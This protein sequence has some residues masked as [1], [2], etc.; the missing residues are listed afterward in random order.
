M[1]LIFQIKEEKYK[2]II[3]TPEGEIDFESGW[4]TYC[5][6]YG[7]QI[8]LD[9]ENQMKQIWEITEVEKINV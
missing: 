9:Y 5:P 6:I 2:R 3:Q 8:F 4:E 1:K 7:D